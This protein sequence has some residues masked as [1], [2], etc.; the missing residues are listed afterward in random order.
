MRRQND[1][2][3][4]V[5]EHKRQQELAK[6]QWQSEREEAL[7]EARQDAAVRIEDLQKQIQNLQGQYKLKEQES[8][9]RRQETMEMAQN[10]ERLKIE[11]LKQMQSEE[12]RMQEEVQ[13][14]QKKYQTEHVAFQ[15]RSES[16][17]RAAQQQFEKANNAMI[18]RIKDLEYKL[19]TRESRPEDRERIAQLEKE[20]AEKEY[21]C[22]RIMEEMKYFKMELQ[23]RDMPNGGGDK[24]EHSGKNSRSASRAR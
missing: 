5:D 10:V 20:V 1:L 18:E 15:V 21:L 3:N 19:V 6:K 13:A 23:H 24:K 8:E 7:R 9:H 17:L 14:L 12:E 16:V 22:K 4:L 2:R 11:F